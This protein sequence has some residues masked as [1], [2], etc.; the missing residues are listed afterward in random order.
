V[1]A[2]ALGGPLEIVGNPPAALLHTPGNAKELGAAAV[3]ILRDRELADELVRR[4]KER[5]AKF[6]R[7][8]LWPQFRSIIEEMLSTRTARQ[9]ER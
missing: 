3:R 8:R 5:A 2:P 1:V 9:R 4:G 6:S 7:E